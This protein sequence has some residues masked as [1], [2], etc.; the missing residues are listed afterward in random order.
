MAG[1]SFRVMQSGD[2]DFF[3]SLID[4]VGW[5]L[6]EGDFHRMLSYEPQGC[7][8]ATLDGR[9]VGMVATTGYGEVG[10]IGNLIVQPGHRGRSIGTRLMERA[11][12]HL[13]Q[14]GADSIRLDAVAKVV[15][16]YQ[17]L[18][19]SHEYRSLRY[20]GEARQNP[21][22]RV[23]LMTRKDLPAVIELDRTFFRL[24]RERIL[25]RVHSDFPD[26]CFT[27]RRDGQLIGYIM[28]KDGSDVVR[29]GPWISRPRHTEAAEE[30]LHGVM[31]ARLGEPL[32][33]GLPERNTAS[34]RVL[35]RNGFKPMP[36][37]HRMCY[38]RCDIRED[39]G[40][41]FGLG[42]PDKG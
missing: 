19:F 4:L 40:G 16:L 11:V 5:G 25:R 14:E 2:A 34:L 10:W 32:W 29:I 39:V 20:K 42:G 1:L 36:P 38:G 30:L 22:E 35:E 26:L 13:T 37:G 23:R 7:F 28:A 12:Q 15:P 31:N 33:A 18:G 41:V 8:I 9:D 21:A 24:D 17:R 6:T 27:A 3:L